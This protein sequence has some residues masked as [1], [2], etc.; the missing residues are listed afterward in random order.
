MSTRKQRVLAARTAKFNENVPSGTRVGVCPVR[1]G[2]EYAT[3]TRS[4]AW[5]LGD[6]S[7]VVLIAGRAGGYHLDHIRVLHDGEE[8]PPLPPLPPR[9]RY[10]EEP[11]VERFEEPLG[12]NT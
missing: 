7:P 12:A 5:Q 10:V 3:T 9:V 2:P 1:G 6:G 8:L 4:R 11:Q